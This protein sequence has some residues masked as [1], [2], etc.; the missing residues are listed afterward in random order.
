MAVRGGVAVGGDGRLLPA[1]ARSARRGGAADPVA[2]AG[3]VRPARSPWPGSSASRRS[4]GTCAVEPTSRTRLACGRADSTRLHRS[5]SGPGG[6]T[7]RRSRASTGA[8]AICP[9][10][11]PAT[12]SGPPRRHTRSCHC[13]PATRAC[14]MQ[15]QTGVSSHR[16][17][18]RRA[19]ARRLLA[20]RVRPRALARARAARMPAWSRR[21]CRADQPLRPGR[22]RAPAPDRHRVGR[23]SSCP[24]DR[25]TMSLVWSDGGYPASAAYRD[26]HHHTIHHHNPWNNGGGAYDH[27]ARRWRSLASTPRTSSRARSRACTTRRAR[28][29]GL[30]GGL[31]AGHRAARSLVV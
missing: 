16:S 1:A 11:S 17:P 10:P 21:V 25:S 8:A 19:V 26:Y 23:D 2:D 9:A 29:R 22:G 3:A 30:L 31:R 4:S 5:W 20:A 6:T 24:I 28:T 7:W 12:P 15:V 13:W 18:L 14:A 27:P